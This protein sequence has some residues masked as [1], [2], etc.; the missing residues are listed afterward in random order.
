MS[1]APVG[2]LR[3]SRL[4]RPVVVEVDALSTTANMPASPPYEPVKHQVRVA[5]AS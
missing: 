2:D 4:I 3:R 5:E 1:A